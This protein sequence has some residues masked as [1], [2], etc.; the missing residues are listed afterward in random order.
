MRYAKGVHGKSHRP[1]AWLDDDGP[2]IPDLSVDDH[3]AV[4]T[5]LLWEDGTSIYRVPL[6][7][8]F[9]RDSEW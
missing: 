8:G 9:G 1:T 4:D 7:I 3:E 5:G 6:P 2:L